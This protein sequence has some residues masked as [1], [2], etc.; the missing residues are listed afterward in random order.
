[1]LTAQPASGEAL[2]S[3][4]EPH[5]VDLEPRSA[6]VGLRPVLNPADFSS[7][8]RE[9]RALALA[10]KNRR[11][12][13]FKLL[14]LINR[15]TNRK[16]L[17]RL[18]ERLRCYADDGLVLV[19][20]GKRY[21]L[22]APR[23]IS[24]EHQRVFPAVAA[25]PAPSAPPEA[26]VLQA[27]VPPP[28]KNPPPPP[29]PDQLLASKRRHEAK[30]AQAR[31]RVR[32]ARQL[33][34]RVAVRL[35]KEEDDFGLAELFKA[36]DIPETKPSRAETT[37]LSKRRPVASGDFYVSSAGGMAIRFHTKTV[38]FL[39]DRLGGCLLRP[40]A[41]LQERD[42]ELLYVATNS[43]Q[44][45]FRYVAKPPPEGLGYDPLADRQ[46]QDARGVTHATQ[47]YCAEAISMA[48]R[49]VAETAR[50]VQPDRNFLPPTHLGAYPTDGAKDVASFQRQ[51]GQDLP[52]CKRFK[53][54]MHNALQCLRHPLTPAA[55]KL[56]PT[57]TLPTALR[58]YEDMGALHRDPNPL[59]TVPILM[60]AMA[61]VADG[62]RQKR[63]PIPTYRV[64]H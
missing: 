4:D 44:S 54:R 49:N 58:R 16:Q 12:T 24:L 41:N 26:Q 25:Q 6:T 61:N 14:K 17:I 59:V 33:R 48:T 64:F 63:P 7:E 27:G 47:L 1:M 51:Y 28:P 57:R 29:D 45:V 62:I 22:L 9:L 56:V 50:A 5:L 30:T 40:H 13:A 3:H 60:D 8:K 20:R 31:N 10:T 38:T 23:D 42:L 2:G 11:L 43:V 36:P 46:Y 32:K 37:D 55:R 15:T 21:Q 18:E 35:A 34:R 52:A 39:A 53:A 19:L